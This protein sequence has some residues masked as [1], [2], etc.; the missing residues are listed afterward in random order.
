[1]KNYLLIIVF[2]MTGLLTVSCASDR[3]QQTGDATS[4]THQ[5]TI[6]P[7][8]AVTDKIHP[9]Q[10]GNGRTARLLENW[11]LLQKIDQNA[12][13]VQ[14]EKNYYKNI[15]DYYLNIRILGL[16]YHELDYKKSLDFLLM[17]LNGIKTE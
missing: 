9:F 1:M 12:I 2:L 7:G 10:D 5:Q 16:E 14:L 15:K 3:E 6:T 8:D 17:T 11:F 13:E 4:D